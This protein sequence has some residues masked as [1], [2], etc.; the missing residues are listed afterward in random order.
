MIHKKKKK[1][2]KKKNYLFKKKKKK[3]KIILKIKMIQKKKKTKNE[4]DSNLSLNN[5]VNNNNVQIVIDSQK[6]KNLINENDSNRT[7]YNQVNFNIDQNQIFSKNQIIFQNQNYSKCVLNIQDN[8]NN[9]KNENELNNNKNLENDKDSNCNSNNHDKIDQNTKKEIYKFLIKIG[10][11]IEVKFQV[12]NGG[13]I[14]RKIYFFKAPQN[15]WIDKSHKIK[16]FE[17]V[18]R[19][20]LNAK[21][22]YLNNN[23]DKF[24]LNINVSYDNRVKSHLEVR[25]FFINF[26]YIDL[27]NFI[28]II[29]INILLLRF[30]YISH[31]ISNQ[32]DLYSQEYLLDHVSTKGDKIS[33]IFYIS[34]VSSVFQFILLFLWFF[35][36]FKVSLYLCGYNLFPKGEYLF[37]YSKDENEFK[38]N[39]FDIYHKMNRCFKKVMIPNIKADNKNFIKGIILIIKTILWENELFYINFC[40]I[41][42]VLYLITN[43]KL[44]LVVPVLSVMNLYSLFKY[45]KKV[46]MSKYKEFIALLILIFIIE[47]IFSWISFLHFPD[48]MIGEYIDRSGDLNYKVNNLISYYFSF[49]YKK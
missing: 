42:N 28:F 3:K 1:R 17:K 33:Y 37:K 16:F 26:K 44:F 23:L 12:S 25:K 47:Y 38:I 7:L 27:I 11:E 6:N 18:P 39:S 19:N 30:Y 46:I 29:I 31:K 5:K 13:Y 48:F 34:A 49:L 4:N 2:K 9:R 43:Y 32:N 22:E 21:L 45:F 24:L 20:S 36:R 40:L 14:F 15:F 35:Y 10:K 8:Q 41:C